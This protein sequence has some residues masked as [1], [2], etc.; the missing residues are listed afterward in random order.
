MRLRS[1]GA[2]LA[3]ALLLS[4]PAAA[5]IV[6][7]NGAHAAPNGAPPAPVPQAAAPAQ[8]D[9]A[10]GVPAATA[11]PAAPA[12]N[13]NILGRPRVPALPEPPERE[14]PRVRVSIVSPEQST[15]HKRSRGTRTQDGDGMVD[16]AAQ[17]APTGPNVERLE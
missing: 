2:G 16:G 8:Q 4:T 15:V 14:A 13:P 9:P 1:S 12:S 6:A 5:Q 17:D 11:A 7:P 10:A 3:L